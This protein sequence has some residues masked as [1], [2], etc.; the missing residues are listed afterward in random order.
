[1]VVLGVSKDT[2]AAQKKF[3]DAHGLAFPLLADA[4]GDVIRSYGVGGMTGSAKRKTF[5]IDSSG[6]VAKVYDEV[7]PVTHAARVNEDL[8]GVK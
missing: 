4:K 1:V 5:L 2:V 3:A 6:R 8:A 7:N